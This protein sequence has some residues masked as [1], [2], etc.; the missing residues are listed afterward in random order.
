M[1]SESSTVKVPGT[2][3]PKETSED[4]VPLTAVSFVPGLALSSVAS[5][6]AVPPESSRSKAVSAAMVPEAT[7]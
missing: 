7:G 4:R 6:G 1:R 5:F 2:S 3:A